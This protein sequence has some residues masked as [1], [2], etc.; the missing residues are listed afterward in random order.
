MNK[1]YLNFL[2]VLEIFPDKEGRFFLKKFLIV[3][4]QLFLQP[5]MYQMFCVATVKAVS[6]EKNM[7]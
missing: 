2:Y 7:E 1:F 5:E 6:A 3:G 4:P